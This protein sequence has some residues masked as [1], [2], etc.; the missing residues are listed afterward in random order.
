MNWGGL[1][2]IEMAA[3]GEDRAEQ[4]GQLFAKVLPVGFNHGQDAVED[5]GEDTGVVGGAG[6]S[7]EDGR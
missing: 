3:G 5:V 6:F 1:S 2:R 4:F 7:A